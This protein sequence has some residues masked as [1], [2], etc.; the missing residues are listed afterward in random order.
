MH[1]T[2]S[3]RRLETEGSLVSDGDEELLVKVTF[4]APVSLRRLMVIGQGDPDTHPSRVKVYVGK[5]DLDF[6]SL[7]DVRPTFESSL[8]QNP[9]GEA[10]VHV[11]PPGAF[12]NV[13]SL[14]FFF[15][16]NHGEGD[17]TS[18]QYIG[19]QGDHSHDKREA[20][21]ATYELLCQHG[22][23]ATADV[24]GTIE[25]VMRCADKG[26]DLVRITVQGKREANAAAKAPQQGWLFSVLDG[27]P[28]QHVIRSLVSLARSLRANVIVERLGTPVGKHPL[29]VVQRRLYA[30]LLVPFFRTH[31]CAVRAPSARSRTLSALRQCPA[32][33]LLP[34]APQS[35]AVVSIRR[36]CQ[37]QQDG[38]LP[39][40]R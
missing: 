11:H 1:A 18:L 32:D 2:F 25:Q 20:V 8:P 29:L 24:D 26:F 30:C 6:Q 40:P 4:V 35:I 36:V 10:F 14:A 9:T 16:G 33:S 34:F 12:T 7:E 28:L 23:T 17:E 21:N 31:S 3:V 22:T 13:T 37:F 38:I 5:E 19:M 15:P 39:R 27:V